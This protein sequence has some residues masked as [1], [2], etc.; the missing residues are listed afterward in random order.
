MPFN[1]VDV[2]FFCFGHGK[3]EVFLKEHEIPAG[4]KIIDMAQDF[5]LKPVEMIMYTVCPNS[6]GTK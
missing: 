6:T 1:E 5:V 3:S 4:V 2:L